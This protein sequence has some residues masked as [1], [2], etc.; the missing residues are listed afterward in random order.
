MI[1]LRRLGVLTLIIILSITVLL[2]GPAYYLMSG[3]AP[4][5]GDWSTA[6]RQSAA[7]APEAGKTPEAIVQIY[8]ARA[9]RWRGAFAVHSWIAIKPPNAPHYTTFEVVRWHI[10]NGNGAIRVHEGDPD[11]YWYGAKPALL[12]D[13]RGTKAENAINKIMKAIEHYPY[14]GAYRTWPGPNSNTF[15]AHILRQVPEL[16]VDLPST[17]IGKDFLGNTKV[18]AR[19]PSR[20]GFQFSLY[21]VFGILVA[22]EEGI[23]I[24][25]AGLS[26]GIDL[27]DLALRLPG[28]G[29]IK[30]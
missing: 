16:K 23:E 8:A 6:T 21:G 26:A 24:N 1:I 12:A 5:E 14:K 17:A 28:F 9:F 7:I 3:R 10:E 29:A 25:L 4:M 20:T 2:L 18:F 11:R 30:P 15:T 22:L 19:A 13:I 27:G